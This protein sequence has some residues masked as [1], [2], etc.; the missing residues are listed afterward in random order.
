M[1]LSVFDIS[2]FRVI[3]SIY[4]NRI[5]FLNTNESKLAFMAG[6]NGSANKN[7]FATYFMKT[8]LFCYS[9]CSTNLDK[10]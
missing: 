4:I 7:V 6:V 8:T 3:G 1:E 5:F 2:V 9:D 10:L